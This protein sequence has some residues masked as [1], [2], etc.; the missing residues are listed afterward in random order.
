[1]NLLFAV[2]ASQFF[3]AFCWSLVH[4]LWQGLVAGLL[5]G[6]VIF[7]TRRSAA[8]TRYKLLLSVLALFL[9][10]ATITFVFELKQSTA[11]NGD[12]SSSIQLIVPQTSLNADVDN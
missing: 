7:S 10:S 11:S 1:M 4:S 12:Q 9:V 6:L 2:T 5:A 8:N 3:Q